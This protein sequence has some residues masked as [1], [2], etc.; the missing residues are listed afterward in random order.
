M[1]TTAHRLSSCVTRFAA[2]RPH[3]AAW[4]VGLLGALGLVA[5]SCA[6]A[7]ED[8]VLTESFKGTEPLANWVLSKSTKYAG[9]PITVKVTNITGYPVRHRDRRH[10]ISSTTRVP[11]RY[12]ASPSPGVTPVACFPGIAFAG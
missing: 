12:P 10:D 6:T 3:A 7:L 11:S 2:H 8:T 9:Q 4:R 5:A 1:V